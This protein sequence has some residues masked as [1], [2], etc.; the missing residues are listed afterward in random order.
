MDYEEL[1]FSTAERLKRLQTELI[2]AEILVAYLMKEI[3]EIVTV[4]FIDESLDN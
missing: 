3:T 4:V 2:A 1:D